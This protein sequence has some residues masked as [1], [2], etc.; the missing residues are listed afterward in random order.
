MEWVACVGIDWADQKHDYALRGREGEQEGGTF[1]SRPEEVHE[2]VAR[3]RARY[4]VG[5]IVVAMEQSRGALLYALSMYEF[6]ALVPINPRAASSYRDSLHLSGAKNDPVDAALIRDFAAAHLDKL[7]VWRADDEATR[8]LRLLVE[9]RRE[10]VNQRTALTQAL[11]ATVK[12]YFPQVLTWLGTNIA[13]LGA[14]LGKWP[15]LALARGARADQIGKVLRGCS[16]LSDVRLAEIVEAIRSAVPLTTDTAIIDA[17]GLR[18]TSMVTLIEQLAAQVRLHEEA[19]AAVWAE[20]EDRELFASFPGAGP[21]LAPRLAAAFGSDR[22]RFADATEMQNYSGTSPVTKQSGKRRSVHARWQ[23][24]KFLHQT[25]HE[26]AEASIPHC[27]WARAYY[28]QQR[29]RGATHRTAIRAL[30]FRWIRILYACWQSRT[31]YDQAAH[32]TELER[33]GSALC[34]RLVA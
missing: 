33:R 29:E 13:L 32:L 24:P 22:S 31:A 19:I 12:Q 2:W 20:H 25:F 21:I 28:H 14:F 34:R 10:L 5:T 15:T 17:L 11:I 30:A 1:A 23:R 16:R 9:Y 3:L 18:V 8:K 4:P 7:Q 27:P 26:F 6:L